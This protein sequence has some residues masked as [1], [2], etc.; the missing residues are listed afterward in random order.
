MKSE[1]GSITL[2]TLVAM[3]F[4]LIIAFTAYTSAMIKL[5]AQNAEIDQI[6]ANYSKDL[7]AE[8]LATLYENLTKPEIRKASQYTCIDGVYCNS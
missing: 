5:Q 2:F 1:K 7:N 8:S 6:V 3:M 4:L